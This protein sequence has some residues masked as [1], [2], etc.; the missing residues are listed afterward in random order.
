[1]YDTGPLLV[2]LNDGLPMA[3]AGAVLSTVK[4]VDAD[5]AAALLPA[6]SVAV[7]APMVKPSEP[8]PV[9]LDMVTV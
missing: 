1:M 9:M 4:V 2:A 7:P 6:A 8:S 3:I 5:E